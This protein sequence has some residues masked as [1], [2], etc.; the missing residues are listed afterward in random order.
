M[1]AMAAVAYLL[2][3]NS[4]AIPPQACFLVGKCK[5]APIKQMSVPQMELEAAVIGVRLLRLIQREMT[6]TID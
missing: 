4:Q 3:T 1:A 2:T 5:V 6:M